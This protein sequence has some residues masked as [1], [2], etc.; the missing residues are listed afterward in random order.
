VSEETVG[1]LSGA[2][3]TELLGEHLLK[4]RSRKVCIHRILGAANEGDGRIL[5]QGA[6]R[7]G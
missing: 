2:F 1:C 6:E 5:T 4:G 7:Y 3:R